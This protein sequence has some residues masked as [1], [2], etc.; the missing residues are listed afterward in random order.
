MRRGIKSLHL[1]ALIPLSKSYILVSKI[2]QRKEEVEGVTDLQ[3]EELSWKMLKAEDD[4]DEES[5]M[6][7]LNPLVFYYAILLLLLM[8]LVW[9]L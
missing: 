7:D 1:G 3:D 8:I 5:Q 4:E 6:Y 2:K 9:R